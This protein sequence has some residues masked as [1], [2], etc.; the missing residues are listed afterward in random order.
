MYEI[1][2]AG[3]I[4][5][6]YAGTAG[7]EWTDDVDLVGE[8]STSNIIPGSNQMDGKKKILQ[9]MYSKTISIDEAKNLVKKCISGKNS[10]RD[11]EFNFFVL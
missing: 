6:V 4:S 8:N 3:S 1:N 10:A 9:E 11:L 7:G 2:T 5:E